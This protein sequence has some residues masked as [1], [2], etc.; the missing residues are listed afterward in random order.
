MRRNVLIVIGVL[1]FKSGILA[2]SY[3]T[4]LSSKLNFDAF[5]GLPISAKYGQIEAVKIVYEIA[6]QKLYFLNSQNFEFHHE[7][8]SKILR[9]HQSLGTFNDN[10]YSTSLKRQYLLANI[11]YQHTTH[12][13]FLELS[14]SDLMSVLDIDKLY[15][16]V[17]SNAYLDSNLKLIL[18]S[19]R[20]ESI[21]STLG[22]LPTLSTSELYSNLQYQ[23]ISK[24]NGAGNLRFITNLKR[25][26][27]DI[28]P[29]DIIVLS[30]TP[31]QI[32]QV[33]G[34]IITEFQTPLSHLSLL[35]Q[36]RHIP[37]MALKN[38]FSNTEIIKANGSNVLLTVKSDTFIIKPIK[39]LIAPTKPKK[40]TNLKYDLN[41]DSLLVLDKV[42]RRSHRYI[43][44]KAHNFSELVYVSRNAGFKTP[45]SAF[46]IPFYYYQE[47]IKSSGT[48]KLINKLLFYQAHQSNPDSIKYILREIRNSI[49]Y[50]PIDN[51]LTRNV[52]RLA[53]SLGSYTHLRFRSSTNA[54][55]SDGFSGAGLYDSKTGVL[56]DVD[57]SIDEAI[58]KVWAS[59]WSYP[60]FMEREYFRIN[61][62]TVYMGILVHRSFPDEAVNGVA[63]TKNLYRNSYF[64]YVVNAQLGNESVVKPTSGVICDQFICYP[65]TL[66]NMY[67]ENNT[68]EIITTSS[69][70]NGQLVMTNEEIKNL[71]NQLKR[72]KNHFY[73][74][75]LQYDD[76]N[77]FAMDVEFKIDGENR[78]LYIK[79][80]RKFNQ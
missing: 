34:V 47:H 40:T 63:I 68:I 1:I 42:H 21:E 44:N 71:A 33:A 57:H 49:K 7:F 41:K 53:K 8:C 59:L 67:D 23:A 22:S 78:V 54:E 11:N 28:K 30:E 55:D 26:Y 3:D 37:V 60:A 56:D 27:S 66:N 70:N 19:A 14:P 50:Y 31:L 72:I 45:E 77:N 75:T 35:G 51:H 16:S 52:T 13:Y 73:N 15:S 64:G 76:F 32:P 38:A 46:A 61:Q 79:Q 12:T 17:L 69:I 65:S 58:K 43:G 36:N 2:Q 24:F 4:T 10:N 29:S 5:S 25:E 9:N 39:S 80:A 18:N 74:Q 62:R 6:T 20:L 48:D